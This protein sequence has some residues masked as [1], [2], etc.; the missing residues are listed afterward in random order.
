MF[1]SAFSISENTGAF[2]HYINLQLF[3]R[4]L[5]RFFNRKNFDFLFVDDEKILACFNRVR[6]NTMH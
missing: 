1:G 4:Q 2:Y 3:P 6:R 5:F